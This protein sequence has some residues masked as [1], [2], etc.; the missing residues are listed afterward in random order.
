MA[1]RSFRDDFSDICARKSSETALLDA[2]HDTTMDYAQLEA[3]TSDLAAQLAV[4]AGEKTGVVS[5]LPNGLE[6]FLGMIATLRA[7][8]DFG[9]L[10][11][12]CSVREL[13]F[14]LDAVDAGVCIVGE[15]TSEE[16]IQAAS[17]PGV[18]VLTVPL[19]GQCRWIDGKGAQIN[20]ERTGRVMLLTSGTTGE[21]KGLVFDVDRLWSSGRAFMEFHEVPGRG[22][23][24]WNILP[25]SYLGGVFNLGLIPIAAEGSVVLGEAFSGRT[26]LRFWQ[27]V[28]RF[29]ISALWLVPT[30][31]RG[32]VQIAERTERA[33]FTKAAD[34]VK[35]CFLGTAPIDLATKRKFEELFGL[36]LLEN[37]ALSETTFITSETSASL[38]RRVE[39]SVGEV[40]PYVDL[41]FASMTDD[42]ENEYTEIEVTTPYMFLGYLD[43]GVPGSMTPFEGYLRTGDIGELADDG[44]TLILKGR[45]RD[46]IKKGGYLIGL[47]EIE[48]VAEQHKD[49]H[50][51]CAVAVP[52]DFYGEDYRL[53]VRAD[54]TD[55]GSAA[56]LVDE[57]RVWMTDQ[58]VQH[59]WP[60]DIHVVTELPK[61]ASGKVRKHA[62]LESI[63]NE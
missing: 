23:R 37:F 22:L 49:V 25:M 30:I 35:I 55:D 38:D 27:E 2:R 18:T 8:L 39:G 60:G 45:S 54:A 12:Q 16:L 48:V 1:L 26:F 34:I 43:M 21:P 10:S 51:A 42:D 4:M 7:G 5:L 47:R 3:M 28:E 58:L 46:I 57:L 17:V 11:P 63:A 6:G 20:A 19:D 15:N 24:F 33:R 9:P 62:L 31:V 32:L 14:W 36:P 52:H 44:K 59:K 13:S 61:T 29:D 41:R 53:F 56:D 40:L 50:E